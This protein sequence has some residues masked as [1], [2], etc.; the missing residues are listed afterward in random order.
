[1]K[2]T[3]YRIH[4]NEGFAVLGKN[5]LSFTQDL[6]QATVFTPSIFAKHVCEEY[7][8]STNDIVP[9]EVY[10]PSATDKAD[11]LT[12]TAKKDGEVVQELSY[13]TNYLSANLK[14]I[15]KLFGDMFK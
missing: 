4:T 6:A 3:M 1:M 8:I 9:F 14:N 5:S 12:L 2:R 13:T 7:D 15:T 10:I 11:S